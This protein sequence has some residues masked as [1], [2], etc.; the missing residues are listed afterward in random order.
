MRSSANEKQNK[1]KPGAPP[2]VGSF[3][4]KNDNSDNFKIRCAYCQELHYS[5]SCKTVLDS[6]ARKKILRDSKRC[7]ICLRKGHQATSCQITKTCRNCSGKHHQ[8]ICPSASAP[9][10]EKKEVAETGNAEREKGDTNASTNNFCATTTFTRTGKGSVL[11][12][13][14]RAIAS[15]GSRSIPVRILFD[16]GS[17]RSYFKS[18]LQRQLKLEP[19]KTETLHL[20]TFG[21]SKCKRQNCEVFKLKIEKKNGGENVELTAISFPTI[22][23]PLS[24][25]VNIED[26]SHQRGLELADFD[27]CDTNS[28]NIDILVGADYYWEIVTGDIA[29]R[30]LAANW[31]GFCLVARRKHSRMIVQPT[32]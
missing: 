1:T 28:D 14:A 25:K 11:L 23:S 29:R 24:S 15:N 6:E 4:A 27:S 8:S 9:K 17:Q 21:E 18:S 2:T 10:N 5:A 7:F 3:M 19:I 31:D 16:T 20:N 12:Q 26:Y 13:T 30:P 22:C 32:T